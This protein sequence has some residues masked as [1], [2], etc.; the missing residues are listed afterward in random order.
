MGPDNTQEEQIKLAGFDQ[1]SWLLPSQL[2]LT[3]PN[4][5]DQIRQSRVSH[6]PTQINDQDPDQDIDQAGMAVLA[7]SAPL[8]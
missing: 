7:S 5:F 8:A 1:I 6:L 2:G 3:K 4:G